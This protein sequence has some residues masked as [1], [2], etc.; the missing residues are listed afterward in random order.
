MSNCIITTAGRAAIA[1]AIAGG[2]KLQIDK[3]VFGYRD[4]LDVNTTPPA[5]FAFAAGETVYTYLNPSAGLVDSATAVWSSALGPTTGDFSYNIVALASGSTLIAVSYRATRHKIK[6]SGFNVGNTL[7][8]N[9]GLNVEN[10]ADVTGISINAQLWQLAFSELFAPLAHNHDAIYAKLGHTH[11]GVYEPSG[12][13]T[14]HKND[15]SAHQAL[16][17]NKANKNFDNIL[18]AEALQNLGFTAG[19]GWMKLPNG[20]IFETGEYQCTGD[21]S[22]SWVVIT[23]PLALS[24]ILV[25]YMA[26]IRHTGGGDSNLLNEGEATLCAPEAVYG[27][28]NAPSGSKIRFWI[29]HVTTSTQVVIRWSA[30][31]IL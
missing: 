2:A 30:I 3:M 6:T 31:G 20:L 12:A 18:Q 1:A 10:I 15:T 5:G 4:G 19:A 25:C 11:S 21:Q 9:F 17:A 27:D 24:K 22:D 23:L 29:R 8:E 7:L 13:V 28:A 14:T 26:Y 16:F